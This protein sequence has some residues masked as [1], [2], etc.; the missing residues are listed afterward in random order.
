VG[1]GRGRDGGFAA[2]FALP[3]ASAAHADMGPI[4]ILSGNTVDAPVSSRIR[5]R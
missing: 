1:V 3:M 5:C 2:M 4:S